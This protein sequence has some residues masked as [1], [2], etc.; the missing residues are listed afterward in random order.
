M[1]INNY[2]EIFRCFYEALSSKELK[3]VFI[4]LERFYP[5][6][7][8]LR[9]EI[10]PEIIAIKY[11]T[12]NLKL[13]LTSDPLINSDIVAYWIMYIDDDI[14]TSLIEKKMKEEEEESK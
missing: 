7:V 2:S 1:E 14:S 13:F 9:S 6:V 4:K 10:E 8:H 12:V 3:P 11:K 5:S